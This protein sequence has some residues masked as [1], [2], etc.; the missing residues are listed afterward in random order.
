[1]NNEYLSYTIELTSGIMNWA[2]QN[3]NWFFEHP[4]KR[5][6]LEMMANILFSLKKMEDS[7]FDSELF[8]IDRALAGEA[9]SFVRNNK[10]F[11][12]EDNQEG[13][14]E[15]LQWA[16]ERFES[17]TPK[18]KTE[19]TEISDYTYDHDFG[20]LLIKAN[21]KG[22]DSITLGGM[23]F[24]IA[25]NSVDQNTMMSLMA[26]GLAA[27]KESKWIAD[28]NYE[29]IVDNSIKAYQEAMTA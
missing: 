23:A 17:F 11:S 19:D 8:V 5:N 22:R 2:E 28:N 4:A 16:M 10:I 20:L 12:K 24:T 18:L 13:L 29:S 7:E 25:M 1:M 9:I 21:E 6:A 14:N 27:V 26:D 3:P 15:Y